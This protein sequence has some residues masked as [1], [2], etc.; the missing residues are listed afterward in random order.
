MVRICSCKAYVEP[1]RLAGDQPPGARRGR[2]GWLRIG[3]GQSGALSFAKF[4]SCPPWSTVV[5]LCS[6]DPVGRVERSEPTAAASTHALPRDGSGLAECVDGSL[7]IQLSLCLEWTIDSLNEPAVP[8]MPPT[9][10]GAGLAV[11]GG[12]EH[13]DL[14]VACVQSRP[15]LGDVADN[16]V[17]QT[18]VRRRGARG[19]GRFDRV[20][21]V[22]DEWVHVRLT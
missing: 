21:G 18:R 12:V 7:E 1:G 3:A 8:G 5:G 15:V 17:R 13:S 2:A 20:S 9:V 22:L 6:P 11:S 4:G 14:V 10:T 19:S 16:L